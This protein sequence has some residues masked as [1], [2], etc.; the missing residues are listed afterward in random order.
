MAGVYIAYPFCS[1]KCSFCNFASGVH[2]KEMEERYLAALR[3]EM[4]SHRWEWTPETVYIGGGTPGRLEAKQL[5]VLLEATPGRPWR[6]ATLEAAPGGI[7]HEA[8]R[9]WRE[10]GINRVSLGVQ[11][12][13]AAELRWTGRRHTAEVVAQE[14]AVLRQEGISNFNIDLIAGL[15][16][17]TE[18]GWR[19]SLEWVARLEAPHVSVYMLEVDEDS[20]LGREILGGGSRYGAPEAPSEELTVEMYEMAVEELRRAGLERYEISNFAR[21]GYESLHNLKYWKL[22]PY[23]GFGVDAHS[24]DGRVRRENT[25]EAAEYVARM[26][27]GQSPCAAERAASPEEERFF[28]GLRLREGVR[29]GDG[30]AGRLPPGVGQHIQE[31]F[32]ELD[33]GVLRLTPKGILFSNEVLQEFLNHERA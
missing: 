22:E 13:A 17:Q 32:L 23:V 33:G 7:T 12:F 20:R 31:G 21:R 28:V 15:P 10:A 30:E 14:A 8:A 16:G 26:E 11:S 29:L 5:R 18:A 9:G 3:T 25:A 1:Q 2:P 19:R 24:F 27:S 4:E 6:E